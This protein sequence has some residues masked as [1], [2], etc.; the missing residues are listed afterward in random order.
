MGLPPITVG[1]P[2]LGGTT[3]A[4]K[5]ITA[6]VPIGTRAVLLLRKLP[7]KVGV[8]MNKKRI[9]TGDRPTGR[10]HLGHYIGSLMN[11]VASQDEFECFFI[12]ADL[13][14][15][16]TKPHKAQIAELQENIRQ[17]V[18]DYLAV[19]I[20]PNQSTIFVQSAIPEICEL[21]TLL[22]MLAN[23]PRLERIPSLKEMAKS[24]NLKVI[25]YGLLGY[26][27]LMAA[28]I[29]LPRANLVPVGADNR[30]NVEL[31]REMARRFNHMYGEV[32]PIPALQDE[33]TLVGT[34]GQAKMSKSLNNAIFISDEA[35]SVERKAMGMFTDPNRL[36]AD[37]PGQVEGNPVFDYHEAFNP[38]KAEVA[39]FKDRYRQGRVGD[40]EVKRKLVRVLNDL[41]DPIREQRAQFEKDP[42][43]VSD[44]LALG[45]RRMRVEARETLTIVREAM[46]LLQYTFTEVYQNPFTTATTVPVEGLA[47]V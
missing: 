3:G 28:D 44:I 25:P 45:N 17:T 36:T 22:G 29:L 43:L 37:T 10:L 7:G 24:A 6:L 39:D 41:L 34:D 30:A 19:G 18:L 21:D 32:F 33:A 5:T 8:T 42:D 46:G 40:V 31:A 2:K 16:T 11:R 27:I 15:L 12:L 47:F 1:Q 26:P 14:T 20:D 4:P 9:L 13:H 38:D 35:A 23:V